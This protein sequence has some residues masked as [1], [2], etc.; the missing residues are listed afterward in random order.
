VKAWGVLSLQILDVLE[1]LGPL[2]S[3]EVESE[4]SGQ[5][6]S[7]SRVITALRRPLKRDKQKKRVYI[8]DWVIDAEGQRKYP[9]ARYAVGNRSDAPQPAPAQRKSYGTKQLARLKG[10]SVFNLALTRADF[11]EQKKTLQMNQD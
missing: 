11:R 2:T 4:L 8:A 9:R 1:R 6:G 7:V 5:I 3:R 10:A